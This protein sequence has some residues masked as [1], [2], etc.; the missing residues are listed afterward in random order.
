MVTWMRMGMEI[1]LHQSIKCHLPC[2]T[3]ASLV[4][5]IPDYLAVTGNAS[6]MSLLSYLL[7]F[8]LK[9]LYIH[10]VHYIE[11]VDMAQLETVL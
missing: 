2:V 5:D 4:C 8:G 7:L 6:Q 3:V 1:R 9:S 10:L 11:M